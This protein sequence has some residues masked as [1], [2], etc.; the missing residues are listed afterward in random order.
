MLI[1]VCGSG[2]SF[3]YT[4]TGT[5]NVASVELVNS[6]FN[7]GMCKNFYYFLKLFQLIFITVDL[8]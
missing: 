3:L 2:S 1:P 5:E 4:G 7:R 6:G 8:Y